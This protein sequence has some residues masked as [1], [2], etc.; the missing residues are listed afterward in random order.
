MRMVNVAGRASV[1]VADGRAVDV[2]RA[3]DGRWP[4]DP[5]ALIARWDGFRTWARESGLDGTHGA[6]DGQRAGGHL[7]EPFA[8]ES[9]GAPAP[10]PG[11]V[12]AI[13]LNYRQHADETGLEAMAHPS[14]FTKFPAAVTG[15][16]ARVELPD[17]DVDWEV[18]LVAVIG[19]GGHRIHVDDAWGHVAGLTVGQ[20]LSDR[21]LQFAADPPQFSLA[22]SYAGFAPMGPVLVTP[23]EFDDPDDLELSCLLNGE[24][25][26]KGRSSEMIFN[27]PDIISRLS[28]VTPLLPGDVIFTGTPAGVGMARSPQRF[29]APGDVLVSSVTGI[30]E[31]HTSFFAAHD[32]AV[33]T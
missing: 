29:L 28:A 14:V 27:V 19:R 22:K 7:G 21:R 17:G 30:G 11:Q 2:E 15:P 18:E 8:P 31:L 1:V 4:S 24:Q 3:S 20:D 13:G 23:D 12:F 9:L 6:G 32:G 25:V 5:Q 33:T 10:R 16:C 26:Q